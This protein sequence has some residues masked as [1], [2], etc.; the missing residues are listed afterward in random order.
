MINLFYN[1]TKGG[2]DVL[3]KLCHSYSVQRKTNRWPLAYFMN[4]INV[5]DIASFIVWRNI[6]NRFNEP[7]RTERKDY[8][9]VLA[10]QMTYEH[11]KSRSLV[12]LSKPHQEI[13]QRFVA[14]SEDDAASTSTGPPPAKKARRRCYLCPSKLS[15]KVKQTCDK[16]RRNVCTPHSISTLL[17]QSCAEQSNENPADSE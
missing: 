13:I 12:G 14:E 15:R 3:D 10:L 17:C 7:V 9:K 6:N 8:L 1:E 11:I 5:A 4:L 2:V 16:C